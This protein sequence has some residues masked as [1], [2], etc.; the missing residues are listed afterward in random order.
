MAWYAS[1]RSSM[2]CRGASPQYSQEPLPEASRPTSVCRF[3]VFKS[4]VRVEAAISI[5]RT[6]GG[7]CGHL[8]S[9]L[10]SPKERVAYPT[11]FYRSV[12][13]TLATIASTGTTHIRIPAG[14][15]L[16]AG[17]TES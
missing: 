12:K 1:A 16:K 4:G 9:C 3:V 17:Q 2:M 11:S 13:C 5:S 7:G 10:R 15:A 8:I 14:R 6:L